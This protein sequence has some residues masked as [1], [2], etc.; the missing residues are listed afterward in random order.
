MTTDETKRQ[1]AHSGTLEDFSGNPT[2]ESE[3]GREND[4]T[5]EFSNFQEMLDAIEQERAKHEAQI[6]AIDALW[7]GAPIVFIAKTTN[8]AQAIRWASI[9][10]ENTHIDEAIGINADEN[11]S[12]LIRALEDKNT[13]STLILTF[14]NEELEAAL[15]RLNVDHIEAVIENPVTTWKKNPAELREAVRKAKG[16]KTRP[17]SMALYM[18]DQ[19]QAEIDQLTA[20]AKTAKKT[21]LPDLD[22]ISGGLYPGLYVIAATSSLGKTTFALQIA[23][24]L[25]ETGNDVLFFSLE[26]S[27]LELVSKS[28]CRLAYTSAGSNATSL[29]I[30]LG[31]ETDAIRD[32]RQL[33]AEK[34]ADRMNII[35]GNF[36]CDRKFI[37]DK[38]RKYV[39]QNQ[40]RPVV[41]IDYLQILQP[42][43]DDRGRTIE[44]TRESVNENVTALRQLSRELNL[45]IFV[46]SSVN[47][48][49][50]LTPIDFES[51]KESG[52]IEYTADVVWGLQLRC[53]QEELF[54]K[55]NKDVKL[56]E[57]RERIK[58]AK[59]QIPRELDLV[60]LKNRYGISS[61]SCALDYRPDRDYFYEVRQ[62]KNDIWI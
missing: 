7:R 6:Y 26:Q 2:P 47:R 38:V 30:R 9:D 53:L 22:K 11:V 8:D 39:K 40:V 36:N 32:A 13:S 44:G 31:L 37:A 50:Y 12:D 58:E 45:T 59:K 5:A 19:L 46:I 27:R 1:E 51:L 62:Q 14:R 4:H 17:D 28:I 61:Y 15:R 20:A 57:K 60:C 29:N 55:T 42:E 25:A 54:Q 23:D 52:G 18:K 21:G 34:I 24:H 43:K 16:P 41:F 49:N 48:T 10:S 33:Y 35:E 56:T 3:K